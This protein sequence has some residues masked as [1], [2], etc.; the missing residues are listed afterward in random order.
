MVWVSEQ[1]WDACRQAYQ[2]SSHDGTMAD[3]SMATATKCTCYRSGYKFL[4]KGNI[5]KWI[6]YAITADNETNQAAIIVFQYDV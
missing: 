1:F 6:E 5:F 2:H 4:R 3:E